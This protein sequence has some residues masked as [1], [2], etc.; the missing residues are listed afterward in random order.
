M[1]H[2]LQHVVEPERLLLTWQPPDDGTTIRTRRIVAELTYSDDCESVT[3][4]YLFDTPDFLEAKAAGFLGYPA[5]RLKTATHTQG[6]MSAFMRRL[7]PRKR[8]DFGAYLAQHWLPNPFTL[9]DFALLGYTG[10]KLPSDGFALVPA[11]DPARLPCEYVTEIAGTRHMGPEVFDSAQVGDVV[12]LQADSANPVDSKAL[13]VMKGDM[14]LGYINRALLPA[15]HGW[16]QYANLHCELVKKA[17]RSGR[18][19]LYMK[20]TATS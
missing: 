14:R 19:L 4:T 3:F 11:F 13:L 7:P 17:D 8:E 10:A 9:S 6:V 12:T 1:T 16:L 15:V 5:F 18:P 2:L 20:L